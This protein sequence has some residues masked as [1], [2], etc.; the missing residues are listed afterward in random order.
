MLDSVRILSIFTTSISSTFNIR[1]FAMLL[2]NLNCLIRSADIDV[3][4]HAHELGM[5]WH[6]DICAG[7][8]TL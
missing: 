3:L 7:L 6:Q 8:L 2:H 4:L 1:A 5:P